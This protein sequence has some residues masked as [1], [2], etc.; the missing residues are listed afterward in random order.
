MPVWW[1]CGRRPRVL[2]LPLQHAGTA[3][4]NAPGRKGTVQ[5]PQAVWRRQADRRGAVVTSGLPL[6]HGGCLRLRAG[7]VTCLGRGVAGA[8]VPACRLRSEGGNDMTGS[9]LAP[10]VIP[11]VAMITLFGWLAAVFTRTAIPRMA[12][13]AA[14]RS[15][16][17]RSGRRL[18]LASQSL[19][20][21]TTSW[22]PDP[23]RLIVAVHSHTT[24]PITVPCRPRSR[25]TSALPPGCWR[26]DCRA[27]TIQGSQTGSQCRPTSGHIRARIPSCLLVSRLHW[28]ACPH[29][30]SLCHR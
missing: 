5:R 4:M 11:I 29:V 18:R 16:R 12:V 25:S 28:P 27:L 7:S 10:I 22:V 9:S 19:H 21:P 6:S 15:L 1:G 23:G 20:P 26:C 2:R 13:I 14:L 3:D 8:A 24:E 30:R 17:R